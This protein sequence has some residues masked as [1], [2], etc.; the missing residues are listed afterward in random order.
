[1]PFLTWLLRLYPCFFLALSYLHSPPLLLFRVLY[2]FESFLHLPHFLP[3]LLPT[4][5]HFSNHP[6]DVEDET[7]NHCSTC[8]CLLSLFSNFVLGFFAVRSPSQS[9]N[10]KTSNCT[11]RAFP[12]LC[13]SPPYVL[14]RSGELKHGWHIPTP[15]E[16]PCCSLAAP[17][18]ISSS[19][20]GFVS[21]FSVVKEHWTIR[22]R[23]IALRGV[24]SFA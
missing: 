1:M 9:N 19:L 7:S 18:S 14:S 2:C 24:L 4:I 17:I 11:Q 21:R 8:T 23:R 5:P 13:H 6:A 16:K 20:V 3:L 10:P 22:A 15:I 12:A